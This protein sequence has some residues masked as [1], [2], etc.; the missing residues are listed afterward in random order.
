M[1]GS[2]VVTGGASMDPLTPRR[3]GGANK[4]NVVRG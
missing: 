2:S 3:F 1:I 4:I